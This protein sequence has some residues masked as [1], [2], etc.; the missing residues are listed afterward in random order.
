[1]NSYLS[2]DTDGVQSSWAQASV[3]DDWLM[4]GEE[5]TEGRLTYGQLPVGLWVR[6][7]SL[8]FLPPLSGS[9]HPRLAINI[10][11]V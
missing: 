6:L 5:T 1:M 11:T 10:Y 3:A 7:P 4:K 9:L 8:S 2:I